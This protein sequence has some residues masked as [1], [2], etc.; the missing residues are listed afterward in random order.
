MY[1]LLKVDGNTKK[2]CKGVNKV[3]KDEIIKHKHFK[4]EL[5]ENRIRYDKITKIIHEN[6]E[7]YT[8]ETSKC[9]LSP[10]NDKKYPSVS[11]Y[12]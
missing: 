11:F 5:E 2:T 1:S 6:H 9:S 8:A 3:V 7:L 12:Q 10:F 4:E